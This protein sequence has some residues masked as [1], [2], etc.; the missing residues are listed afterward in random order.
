MLLVVFE[1]LNLPA[2]CEVNNLPKKHNNI[3][4]KKTPTSLVARKVV[5]IKNSLAIKR[6][7]QVAAHLSALR[8]NGEEKSW[9]GGDE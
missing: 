2:V 7:H 6:V 4:S 9:Q 5:G 8:S 1:P 3:S